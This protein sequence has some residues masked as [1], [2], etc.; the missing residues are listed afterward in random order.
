MDKA[1]RATAADQPSHVTTNRSTSTS[2]TTVAAVAAGPSRYIYTQTDMEAFKASATKRDLLGFATALG[3]SCASPES[4]AS[5]AS[6]YRYDPSNPL[7]GLS[8]ATASLHGSM[9]HM[10]EKWLA[11][12]PPDA[13]VR[14]RFGNPI[15]REWHERLVERSG[16]IIRSALDCHRE[17]VH[18]VKTKKKKEE[19]GEEEEEEGEG[20]RGAGGPDDTSTAGHDGYSMEI[21]KSCSEAGYA[22]ASDEAPSRRVTVPANEQER[23]A[24][25]SQELRAY[26]HQAFGHPIRLDYGTGH[27]SSFLILIFCLFKLRCIGDGT[28]PPEARHLAPVALA[29]FSQYLQVTRGLQRD[30]MLEPAG[31]HGVW[32]LDDYHCLPFYFG[33]CQLQAIEEDDKASAGN[34]GSEDIT[35]NSIHD[36]ALLKRLGDTYMYLSCIRY[37]KELKSSVPFFESSPMLDDISHL[38]SW[39]RVSRGLLRLYDGEVLVKLPVVQHFIFGTL[40]QGEDTYLALELDLISAALCPS[41]N[42]S[43]CTLY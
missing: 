21:L 7:V 10:A 2:S 29:I 13:T 35:P 15:F 32:G 3:R 24:V 11:E 23:E 42:I 38:P 18:D 14:A 34:A 36:D 37:I 39:G 4:S 20:S 1:P 30:Y 27:E 8:P 17:Y 19:E 22:A 6:P 28:S 33:A 9:R 31:S 12:L 16:A 26:L 40:F 43:C 25:V 41:H 5:A